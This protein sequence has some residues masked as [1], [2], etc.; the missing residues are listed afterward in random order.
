MAEGSHR[1]R[2][3]SLGKRVRGNTLREFESHTL[4]HGSKIQ[5][6]FTPRLSRGIF[7][8]CPR[9][10]RLVTNS[11]PAKGGAAHSAANKVIIIL[12]PK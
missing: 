5:R 1:G 12:K 2:V 3:R 8:V 6:E 9:A 4:R 11:N 7:P 10:R